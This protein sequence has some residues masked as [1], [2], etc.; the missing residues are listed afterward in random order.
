M[1]IFLD[2][3]ILYSAARSNGAV[4]ELLDKLVF[5]GHE[6][7]VDAYVAEE[8]RRNIAAK[9]PEAAQALELILTNDVTLKGVRLHPLSV[10]NRLPDKDRPVLAAAVGFRCDVLVTGDSKHFGALFGLSVDGTEVLSPRLLAER[11]FP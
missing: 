1:R 5:A 10:D 7:V 11:L 2:A 8:A 4:R 3:N 6:L 9:Y